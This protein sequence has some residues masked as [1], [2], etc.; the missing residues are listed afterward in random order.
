MDNLNNDVTDK[1]LLEDV[2][3]QKYLTTI[4]KITEENKDKNFVVNNGMLEKLNRVMKN[5]Q[6][7]LD[8]DGA[9]YKVDLEEFSSNPTWL[10]VSIRLDTLGIDDVDYSMFQMAINSANSFSIYPTSTS[11]IEM[12]LGLKD[13]FREDKQL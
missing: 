9:T 13:F 12:G 4:R 7:L 1:E 3:F 11:E 5:L 8:I 2:E 10:Y 6:T